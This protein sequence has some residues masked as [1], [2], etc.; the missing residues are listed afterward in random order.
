[1][2]FINLRGT[3]GSG[4]T[5]A[6]KALMGL[7]TKIEPVFISGRKKPIFYMVNGSGKAP[8][9]IMGH[10]ET[11]C[12]G[13]DTINKLDDVFKYA[14]Q[15][16]EDHGAEAVVAEGLLLGK[17]VSRIVTM[18]NPHLLYIDTP[19]DLCYESVKQR[20]TAKIMLGKGLDA[21]HGDLT[22][23]ELEK[24]NK[25]PKALASDHKGILSAVNR[26]RDKVT[27]HDCTRDTVLETMI[28]LLE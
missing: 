1:M 18:D 5:T 17:D 10:Y 2:T 20:R 26:L 7:C 25:H 4:K 6:I 15:A 27:V 24:I 21:N 9:A 3:S 11:A 23:E 12:G 19:T 28:E 22:T 8:F 16:M 14:R 13:C